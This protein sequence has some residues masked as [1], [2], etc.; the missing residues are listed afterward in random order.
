[1]SQ[2]VSSQ[3]T[4]CA[5]YIGARDHHNNAGPLPGISGPHSSV[6]LELPL[7]AAYEGVHPVPTPTSLC[8]SVPVPRMRIVIMIVG[9]R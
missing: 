3:T 4:K 5:D 1:M 6:M 7:C 9:T 2:S 8:A